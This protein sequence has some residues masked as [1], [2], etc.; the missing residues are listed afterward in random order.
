MSYHDRKHD[1]PFSPWKFSVTLTF[2]FVSYIVILAKF[3]PKI[4]E[5]QLFASGKSLRWTIVA[6]VGLNCFMEWGFHRYV[7]HSPLLSYLINKIPVLRWI[8]WPIRV[9]FDRL[10]NRHHEVHHPLTLVAERKGPSNGPSRVNHN[11]YP[12]KEKWQHK[13][14]YFPWFTFSGFG[15]FQL[16][17]FIPAQRYWPHAPIFLGGILSL[18]TSLFLYEI[19]HAIDHWPEPKL[20]PIFNI[21][22]IGARLQE[23]YKIHLGHHAVIKM[24]MNISGFFLFPFADLLLLTYKKVNTFYKN[25]EP[26]TDGSFEAPRPWWFVCLLDKLAEKAVE[27]YTRKIQPH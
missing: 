23:F 13:A 7:L 3:F 20:Q 26:V 9:L 19:R 5:I 8:L 22:F 14:S 10:Y 2:W 24:N 15:I 12:I 18:G 11:I 16:I 27:A 17:V 21:W 6:F 4:W 1:P 25:G